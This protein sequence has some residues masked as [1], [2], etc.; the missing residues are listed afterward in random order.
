MSSFNEANFHVRSGDKAWEQSS[1][2]GN[3]FLYAKDGELWLHCRAN[4]TDQKYKPDDEELNS[5]VWELF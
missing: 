2:D 5:L 1:W 3:S 4:D